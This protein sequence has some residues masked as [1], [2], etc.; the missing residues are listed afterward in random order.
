VSGIFFNFKGDHKFGI[1]ECMAE[2]LIM[3]LQV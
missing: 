3:S 1:P 2:E